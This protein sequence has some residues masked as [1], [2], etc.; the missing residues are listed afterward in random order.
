M[1]KREIKVGYLCKTTTTITGYYRNSNGWDQTEMVEF[2]CYGLKCDCD[3]ISFTLQDYE[4]YIDLEYG[5]RPKDKRSS[6]RT[7]GQEK[8]TTTEVCIISN[9]IVKALNE[10]FSELYSIHFVCA[11][12]KDELIF[13]FC[14]VIGCKE[15]QDFERYRFSFNYNLKLRINEIDKQIE[16]LQKQRDNLINSRI[17]YEKEI[18]EHAFKKIAENDRI[19]VNAIIPNLQM[20]PLDVAIKKEIGICL[21]IC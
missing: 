11:N 1:D 9:G 20:Y 12:Q 17:P 21:N 2:R 19:S 13:D 14:E 15:Y 10:A 6:D 4:R 16:D 18:A 8:G 5:Y 3:N 7:W